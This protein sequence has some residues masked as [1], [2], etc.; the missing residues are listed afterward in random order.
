MK[1]YQKKN[2]KSSGYTITDRIYLNVLS[3]LL[4]SFVFSTLILH[5]FRLSPL[6][7]IVI[8]GV[9]IQGFRMEMY[10]IRRNLVQKFSIVRY[11][12]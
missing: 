1:T 8:S 7:D 3:K 12:Q 5:F 9:I 11:H 6:K 2:D 4:L 10:D